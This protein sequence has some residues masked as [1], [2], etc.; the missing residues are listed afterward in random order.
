MKIVVRTHASPGIGFGHLN[1]CQILAEAIRRIGGD[2]SLIVNDHPSIHSFVGSSNIQNLQSTNLSEWPAADGCIVDLYCYDV[3]FYE[4]LRKKY[5]HII[6]FDDFEFQV[7]HSV[8][9]V[10]NGN[11]C[12]QST[13][14]PAHLQTFT[15]IKYFLMR[16]EFIGKRQSL[17]AQNVLVCMGGSDPENQTTRLLEILSKLTA[18]SIDA[19]F[20]PG[21]EDKAV[22]QK[23][24]THPQITTHFAVSNMSDLMKNAAFCVSGAGSMMYE[25]AYMGVPIACMSLIDHQRLIAEAFSKEKAAIYLG[26]FDEI[27]DFQIA[28]QLQ[29]LDKDEQTRSKLGQM[30]QTLVDGKGSQR[31]A[32]DLRTW[33]LRDC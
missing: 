4:A 7:P 21:F 27:T 11:I 16:T 17:N 29:I 2:V 6:I 32:S 23:W 15:G 19:V 20:G 24:S 28:S 9:A 1:R 10:I 13:Q 26:Y 3:S 31:L 22:I 18:R 25:L 5:K 33:L 14:Y 12:T 30:A 8:S